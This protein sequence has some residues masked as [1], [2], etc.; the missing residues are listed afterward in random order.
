[1]HNSSPLLP[2]K[3]CFSVSLG[4]SI[5]LPEKM[6]DINPCLRLKES[7]NLT[8]TY[9]DPSWLLSLPVVDILDGPQSDGTVLRTGKQRLRVGRQGDHRHHRV[10]WRRYRTERRLA[11]ALV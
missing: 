5:L 4:G 8:S 7:T 11:A 1:M 9:K 2:F 3:M 10:M 6:E